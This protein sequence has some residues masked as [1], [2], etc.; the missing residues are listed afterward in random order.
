MKRRILA[1]ILSLTMIFTV[2]AVNLSAMAET[3]DPSIALE[4]AEG[5]IG[6]DV[7]IKVLIDNNPG[8]WGMDLRISYDK[9]V[10]TLTS[11]DNGDFYQDAEWTK[12]NLNSDV[13]ILS[14]EASGLDNI[15]IQSGTLATLNFKVSDTAVA[16]DYAVTASYNLGDIINVEFDDIDFNITNG[17]V[18]IKAKPVSATGVTLN[19]NTL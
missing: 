15:T 4:D 1:L 16:G 7:S 2:S 13:Y 8:I 10:L 3:T 6:Q 9:N 12:G 18:T 11:V 14:Y 5:E 17:K 19:K